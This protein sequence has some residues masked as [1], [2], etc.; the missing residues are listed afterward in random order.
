MLMQPHIMNVNTL[1]AKA[2]SSPW[3]KEQLDQCTFKAS[4][5][6]GGG[7]VLSSIANFFLALYLL[8]GKEPGSE[9]F[10]KALGTL[11]WA[12]TVVIG[13]PLLVIMMVVFMWLLN[14]IQRITGLERDDLLNP[15]KTV[16]RQVTSQ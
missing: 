8:N 13:L 4:L 14:R 12:G 15:G 9:A 10:V 3:I 5:G 11:N 1:Q 7:M 2:A 6:M 16:R